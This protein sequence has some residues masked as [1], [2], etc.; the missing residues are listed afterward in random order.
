MEAAPPLEQPLEQQPL[1]QPPP[2]PPHTGGFGTEPEPEQRAQAPQQPPAVGAW[3][4]EAA[5]AA[6]EAA[7][8]LVPSSS[9][10]DHVDQSVF[11]M[12][13]AII[14]NRYHLARGIGRGKYGKVYE[15]RDLYTSEAVAVKVVMRIELPSDR[16]R[17][18]EREVRPRRPR[19]PPPAL[20]GGPCLLRADTGP[21]RPVDRGVE[22]PPP[23]RNTAARRASLGE[24]RVS[25]HGARIRQRAVRPG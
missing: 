24:P 22:A 3:G 2:Q 7:G 13:N 17:K 5:A 1:E 10:R 19:P 8:P 25:G 4:P 12:V 11:E 21:G 18:A 20:P 15:A 16:Q 9:A 6:A 23:Q 14:G